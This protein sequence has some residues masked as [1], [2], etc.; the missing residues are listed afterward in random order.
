M[1]FSP[2]G[3]RFIIPNAI[4]SP[5]EGRRR[6][7]IQEL[8][9]QLKV[10]TDAGDWEQANVIMQKLRS[11]ELRETSLKIK[12]DM[13]NPTIQ[14]VDSMFK[15]EGQLIRSLAKVRAGIPLLQRGRG[16]A[17]VGHLE[18]P[19]AKWES[20]PDSMLLQF[21]EQIS[22]KREGLLENLLQEEPIAIPSSPSV[23]ASSPGAS[24][25]ASSP[26]VVASSPSVVSS[27]LGASASSER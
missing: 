23:V 19:M 5:N 24:A 10:C 27:S 11:K 26:S 22:A 20:L 9:E 21:L 1:G 13:L 14:N 3:R 6:K 15:V 16:A 8:N 7:Q 2:T 25:I 4:S 12:K 18:V 17:K